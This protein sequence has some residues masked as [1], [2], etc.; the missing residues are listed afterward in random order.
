MGNE[1]AAIL[2]DWAYD[3]YRQGRLNALVNDDEE[4]MSDLRTFERFLKV[5]IWCIQED[6][7]LRPPMKKEL[8]HSV[9]FS[10]ISIGRRCP[11][12][13]TTYT[14]QHSTTGVYIILTQT[15][16]NISLD[17]SLSTHPP[18]KPPPHG[19]PPPETSPS[20]SFPC[21]TI[22]LF[23]LAIYINNIPEKT[24]VWSANGDNPVPAGSKVTLTSNGQLVLSDP[25]WRQTWTS[26]NG[27]GGVTHAAMLNYWNF[28]LATANSSNNAWESFSFPTDTILPSQELGL[29]SALFA[30]ITETN[31][32]SGRL[33]LFRSPKQYCVQRYGE[34]V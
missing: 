3:C 27:G 20:D 2:A 10:A 34:G 19:P 29:G 4:V 32:S 6:P 14:L 28:V 1:E 21:P 25:N 12:A 26:N 5:A 9:S 13:S 7:S 23:L 16:T 15:H 18:P 22:P 30:H 17:S 8:I 33:G 11:Q 31:Y 24:I